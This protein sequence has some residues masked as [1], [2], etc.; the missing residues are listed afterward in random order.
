MGAHNG[1]L[2][3]RRRLLREGVAKKLRKR[4]PL[5]PLE[6]EEKTFR[7]KRARVKKNARSKAEAAVARR[8]NSFGTVD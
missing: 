8:G 2:L 3:L 4:R 1:L 5:E 6:R 7:K